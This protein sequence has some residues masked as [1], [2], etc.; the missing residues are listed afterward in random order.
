MVMRIGI[1][2]L[3]GA[4]APQRR[5]L[6]ELGHETA[7]VRSPDDL[8]GLGGLVLPG[9]EST[10]QTLLLGSTGLE[11]A[12]PP[13]VRAGLPTLGTC[14]GLILLA[15]LG[16]LD[17]SVSRNGYGSQ[18]ASRVAE[19]DGD[20]PLRLVLIRGPRVT[21]TGPT[22]TTVARYAGEPVWVREGPVHGTTF[23]PEL[24]DDRRVHDAVFG[25][26]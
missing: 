7:I 3:Q 19:S 22:V 14:A 1:L 26:G 5:M 12:L 17:V 15:R 4:I 20:E 24:T 9:G 18:T 21:R 13:V 11:A 23:H 2:G 8:A 6:A 10:T 25:S 16:L